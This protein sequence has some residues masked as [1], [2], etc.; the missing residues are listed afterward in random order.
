MADLSITPGSV[1]PGTNNTS[2]AEYNFAATVTAGQVVYLN[3]SNLWA[4]ADMNAG[5]GTGVNDVIGIALNGGSVGQPAKVDVL[6]LNGITI[7][8]TVVNGT[9]YYLSDTAGGIS[10][11]LP[12][13]NDY[14]VFLGLGSGTTKIVLNPTRTGVII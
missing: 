1:L 14:P 8:A 12:T 9:S 5:L 2:R 3:A 6:D 11:T 10:N 13:T 4:L 7:G